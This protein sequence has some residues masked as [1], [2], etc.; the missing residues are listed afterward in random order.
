MM[1]RETTNTYTRAL[2]DAL[3]TQNAAQNAAQNSAQK[4]FWEISACSALARTSVSCLTI[5]RGSVL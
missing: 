4:P 5:M 3:P 2:H 1:D